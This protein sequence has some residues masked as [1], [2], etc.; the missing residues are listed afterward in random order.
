MNEPGA[1]AHPLTA[2]GRGFLLGGALLGVLLLTLL[3][4]RGFGLLAARPEPTPPPA[5]ER[6]GSALLVPQGSP[7]RQRLLTAPAAAVPVT[8]RIVLPGIV[9]SDPARTAPILAPLAGRVLELKVRLGDRVSAGQAL[10]VID[11][12]DLAQAYDDHTRAAAS[13]ALNQ[14]NLERQI[15]QAK[16]GAV[17]ERDL[18]QARSDFTQ[19]QAEYQRTAARLHAVGAGRSAGGSPDLIV[20][21]PFAGSVTALSVATGNMLN[22]P[23]QPLMTLVQLQTVWVTA[24]AAERDLPFLAAGAE[25]WIRT[26][27]DPEHPLRGTV[28]TVSD[29]VEPDSRRTKVRITVANDDLR[30]KPNMFATISLA[31]PAQTEVVVPSSALL[32]NND[33][34]SVFV[35]TAP[36]TFERR[37]VELDLQEG[38]R[39]TIRSGIKVGEQ[40]VVRGGILLND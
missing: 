20:R 13:F 29:V 5:F 15:G 3:Y 17:S 40:V 14:R 27:A 12:P 34:T 32:M 6:H 38:E 4:T 30:L 9:E 8:R 26:D 33:R 25:A 7:L 19:A 22:D 16:I 11:S 24:F 18:E 21:A 39:V 28:R 2:R 23:T 31:A 36:W 1:D 37:G 10:A 35:A